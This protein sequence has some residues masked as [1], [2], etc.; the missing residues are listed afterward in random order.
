MNTVAPSVSGTTTVGQQLTANPGTWTG[1]PAPTFTYQWL[2][3]DSGGA[4]C[5]PILNQTG[6]TYTLVAGDAG[7]T[8]AVTVTGTNTVRFVVCG[9]RSRSVRSPPATRRR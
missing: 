8:I 5:A 9:P 7:M 6:L 4:N 2:R 3:C 1:S